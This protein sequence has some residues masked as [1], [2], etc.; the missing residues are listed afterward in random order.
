MANDPPSLSPPLQV[1]SYIPQLARS[2]PDS[3]ACSVCTVDGQRMSFGDVNSKFTLQ[4]CRFPH[5]PISPQS[6]QVTSNDVF[7]KPFIYSIC[8][9]ELGANLV[10]QYVSHEP[11]G[12]NFNE[13]C[14]DSRSETELICSIS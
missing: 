4:S 5:T 10:H 6:P 1:A 11:S 13:I 14:L 7:S 9:N 2:S 3:W 12:R 8:L